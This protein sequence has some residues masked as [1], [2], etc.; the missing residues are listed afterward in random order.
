MTPVNV[1]QFVNKSGGQIPIIYYEV[2]QLKRATE[3]TYRCGHRQFGIEIPL[4]HLY[5]A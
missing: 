3:L 5:Y 2:R 4:S 1:L